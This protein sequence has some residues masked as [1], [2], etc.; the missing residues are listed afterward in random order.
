MG[1]RVN[2]ENCTCPIQAATRLFPKVDDE[3]P[4]MIRTSGL[5][6]CFNAQALPILMFQPNPLQLFKQT[7][8]VPMSLAEEHL[9]QSQEV[10]VNLLVECRSNLA[11]ELPRC[12]THSHVRLHRMGQLS[13]CRLLH[14]RLDQHQGT[15]SLLGLFRLKMSMTINVRNK[16]WR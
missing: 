16:N 2:L 14:T 11:K 5:L 10:V 12:S 9:Q 13:L 1:P 6:L 7:A 4:K 15:T 8:Q 3:C